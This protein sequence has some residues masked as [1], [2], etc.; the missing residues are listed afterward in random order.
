MF[1]ERQEWWIDALQR[2]GCYV[3]RQSVV[4]PS[5][6]L[7]EALA[8]RQGVSTEAFDPKT[9]L[10]ETRPVHREIDGAMTKIWEA[11]KSK[12]LATPQ[13][14][15]QSYDFPA[16]VEGDQP[17]RI[18]AIVAALTLGGY[19]AIGIDEKVGIEM[20]L[21][22]LGYEDPH[23]LV[24]EMYPEQSGDRRLPEGPHYRAGAARASTAARRGTW[25]RA[26]RTWL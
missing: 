13:A 19:P 14:I 21:S 22:E 8:K 23:E 15:T 18:N 2:I 17:A 9:V 1:K 7:R 16:I 11:A 26:A 25:S 3:L 4:K 12:K 20:L 6:K 5:G 10:L 24:E